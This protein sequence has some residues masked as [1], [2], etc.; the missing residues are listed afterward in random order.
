MHHA[1]T[2][3]VAARHPAV[4]TYRSLP[5]CNTLFSRLSIDTDNYVA[6]FEQRI[7]SDAEDPKSL[8]WAQ[9]Q[10]TIQ[11]A[12]IVHARSADDIVA[13]IAVSRSSGC[14][15]AIRGGGHSDM[16]GAS[17]SPGGITVNMAGLSTIDVDEDNSVARVGAGAKWGAVYAELEKSNRTVVGGRLTSVGVGGLLLGGG[18]SHFSGMHGWAC[19]NVRSFEVWLCEMP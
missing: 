2:R 11:P 5:Q 12:C 7:V 1:R 18:L 16:R 19:D 4:R 13:V 6:D 9:Q 3:Y 15:F 17:N 8:F 14:P 10:Q